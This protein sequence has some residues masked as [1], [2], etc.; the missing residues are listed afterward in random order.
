MPGILTITLN[1]TVDLS[2]SVDQVR[3]GPKLR[4]DHPTADP[5]GGGINVSRAIRHLGGDSLAFIALGG[6]TGV[7]LSALLRADG[8]SFREFPI[9]GETRQSIAV[10][11]RTSGDQYRFVMPGPGWSA[12]MVE[13]VLDAIVASAG[14]GDLVVL[15]GSNPPGL[16]VDFTARLNARLSGKGVKVIADTSGA[17]LRHLA[18]HPCGLAVLRM[19]SAEAEDL[20]GRPL[21]D[22]RDSA[23]FARGLVSAGVA[24][25]VVIARGPDG[26]T[27]VTGGRVIHC[28]R[29]ITE[30][31][32][33]VGAGDS[34][35]GA[36]ALALSRG[37]DWSEALTRG[38]AA[39]SAAVL[40]QATQ[41]CTREDAERLLAGCALSEL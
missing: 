34:F 2:T 1:P 30:I 20:A 4:C 41:L 23:E 28:S 39:A 38:T 27:L 36:F 14:A 25:T 18:D 15:S 35:V 40:T 10:T 24:G 6:A 9:E 12:K 8:I 13:Q 21:P 31:V 17:A 26:S 11:D 16:P 7:Q 3:P 33:A 29:P 22:R 19:D 37:G 32:S 5:G